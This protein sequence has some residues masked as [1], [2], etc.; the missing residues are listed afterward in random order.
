MGFYHEQSR[1]DRD[2]YVS[3]LWDNILPGKY[4]LNYL[5]ICLNDS[6]FGYHLQFLTRVNVEENYFFDL[7]A[8]SACK[9]KLVMTSELLRQ[10]VLWNSSDE[11]AFLATE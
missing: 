4:V 10:L 1:P 7:Y 9:L 8:E 6:E 11:A 3:I 5:K 2:I